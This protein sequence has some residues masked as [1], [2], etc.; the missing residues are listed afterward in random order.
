MAEHDQQPDEAWRERCRDLAARLV[1]PLR[2]VARR[3]GYALGVHGSLARD[4]DLIAAPWANIACST[5]PVTLAEAIREKAAELNG[6]IAFQKPG[7]D[8]WWF[9]A[10]CPGAK[11]H[12]RLQWTFHL[13]GG[14]YIDLCVLPPGARHATD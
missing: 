1:E 10:G 14:P 5:H 6:G 9:I 2:E 7:E 8:T 4:I 11:P 12:G 3:Y 13:G